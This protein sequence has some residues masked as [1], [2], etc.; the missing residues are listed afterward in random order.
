[1]AGRTPLSA[2]TRVRPLTPD[3]VDPAFVVAQLASPQVSEESW[4]AFVAHRLC[5]THSHFGGI[6][7]AED[8]RGYVLGLACYFVAASLAHGRV[9]LVDQLIAVGLTAAQPVDLF[10]ALLASLHTR[11]A[12]LGCTAVQVLIPRDRHR[13]VAAEALRAIHY[14]C[15]SAVYCR[16]GTPAR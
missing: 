7:A 5:P 9:L 6:D 12:E 8:A 13:S 4:R 3:K 16:R 14:S 1:M 11:A 10:D 15:E 2:G